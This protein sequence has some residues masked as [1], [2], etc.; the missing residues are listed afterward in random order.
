[1][2]HL[3]IFAH[4]NQKSFCKGIVD[5]I[6]KSSKEN[7][8]IIRIRDLYEIGFDPI[9]KPSDFLAL[10]S[11]KKPGDIEIEQE[12][13]KWAD[14][15][16][17]VYPVW[18]SGFPAV[19]KGYVDR[20][21]SYGFAYDSADGGIRGLLTDKKAL[22]FCTT[23]SPNELYEENG[24]HNSMKQITG[25]GIFNFT[26]VEVMKYTFFGAVP[27]VSDEIRKGYLNDVENIVKEFVK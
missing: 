24:M 16:T 22:V 23:G 15:I 11:G 26:G 25:E 6:E 20:V 13:I 12:H 9:L 4:P 21:F 7:G 10:E 5:T 14:I 1:M 8:A 18:W 19:L 3:V 2:N 27:Y 17:F